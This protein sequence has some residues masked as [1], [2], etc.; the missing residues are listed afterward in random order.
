[1]SYGLVNGFSFVFSLPET[2]DQ[3]HSTKTPSGPSTPTTG[4]VENN[5]SEMKNGTNNKRSMYCQELLYTEQNYFDDLHMVKEVFYKQLAASNVLTSEELRALFINWDDLSRVSK[6][7]AKSLKQ[8]GEDRIGRAVLQS[9][10]ELRA[11]VTFCQFQQSSL[12]F[13]ESKSKT[14][15]QF[16]A[17]H[18]QCCQHPAAR[19][20]PLSHFLL[21]PMTRVT[22]YPLVLKEILKYTPDD[23][24]DRESLEKALTSLKD[25]CDEVNRVATETENL[26]MLYWCQNHVKCEAI[27][28][29]F[30]FHSATNFLGIF[31]VKFLQS[32]QLLQ[33]TV[34]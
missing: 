24:P 19:G 31:L 21:I 28:P 8:Y 16:Q 32:R 25:L 20:L 30:V 3:Q 22:K 9:L 23:H 17:V 1:M 33:T 26:Q 18:S 11:F 14:S 34:V 5:A 27:Q 6:G 13:L 2:H 10:N 12:E 15:T 4:G 29:K 7:F